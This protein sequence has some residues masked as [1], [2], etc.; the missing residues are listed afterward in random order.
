MITKHAVL[1]DDHVVMIDVTTRKLL[2][3]DNWHPRSINELWMLGQELDITHFWI[4]PGCQ[5]DSAGYAALDETKADDASDIFDIFVTKDRQGQL[6]PEPQSARCRLADNAGHE[7]LI[8]YPHRGDF[9]WEI[10]KPLDI[11]A[12]IDYLTT[13][14]GVTVQWS[15]G[16]MA[17][18]LLEMVHASDKHQDWTREPTIDMFTLPYGKAPSL[19]SSNVYLKS[20]LTLDMVGK[21]LHRYDKNSAYLSAMQGLTT[22]CGDPVHI[23]G[24]YINQALPGIYHVAKVFPGNQW[25]LKDLPPI[26]VTPW[27]TRDVL[28][29]ALQKGYQVTID[30]A[31]QFSEKH[32]LFRK[33]AGLLWDARADLRTNTAKYIYAPGRE[34]ACKTTKLIATIGPGRFAMAGQHRFRHVNWWDDIVGKSAVAMLLNLEK[35]Y[36]AGHRPVYVKNDE[37][38]YLS[39][40]GDP[41][42]A[43]PGILD[44]AGQL[45]G[46]KHELSLLLT[47]EI[48]RASWQQQPH[49]ILSFLKRCSQRQEVAA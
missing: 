25:N 49:Q 36:K 14:L 46:Y 2:R 13:A 18:S 29:L 23:Q 41:A 15:P 40:E 4:M 6:Y 30:Q 47:E 5:F 34:N 32:D 12:T 8:C 42:Q 27:V 22:G 31:W 17:F 7:V 11:L 24:G 38:W 28:Q 19:T 35:F 10:E 43:V 3:A 20:A 26:I 1:T 44:R 21:Y 33:W 9:A 45:G 48:I 16:H 39:S 37:V